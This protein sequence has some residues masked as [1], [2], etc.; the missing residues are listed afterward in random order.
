MLTSFKTLLSC[1][2]LANTFQ[3][4]SHFP[5]VGRHLIAK[6][7]TNRT[8]SLK[9]P[10]TVYDLSSSSHFPRLSSL[11]AQLLLSDLPFPNAGAQ[12]AFL[13]RSAKGTPAF[14]ENSASCVFEGLSTQGAAIQGATLFSDPEKHG[15][16][17]LE[18]AKC[19]P[20]AGC[21]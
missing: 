10:V 16:N 4:N 11:W 1:C 14:Q 9:E 20:A 18:F 19:T 12:Q 21:H 6:S 5:C 2:S 7:Q 17:R 3:K 13:S 8:S 15:I